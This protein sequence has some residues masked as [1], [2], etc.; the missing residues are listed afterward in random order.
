LAFKTLLGVDRLRLYDRDRQASEKCARSLA[1]AGLDI[2][3]GSSTYA[4][5]Q[6]AKAKAAHVAA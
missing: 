6:G 2:T 1:G 4:A 5:V 3:F